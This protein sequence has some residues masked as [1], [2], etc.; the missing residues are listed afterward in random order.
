MGYSNRYW[1][2][3][4]FTWDEKLKVHCEGGLVKFPDR[5]TL[6]GYADRHC[7]SENGWKNCSVARAMLEYY[8]R[9]EAEHGGEK[10]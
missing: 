8:E 5:K 10:P 3:P 9:K 1:T 7:S 4:F 6:T 2:C